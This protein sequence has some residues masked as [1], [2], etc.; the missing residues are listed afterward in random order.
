MFG[1]ITGEVLYPYGGAIAVSPES[2]ITTDLQIQKAFPGI[3][4]LGTEPGAVYEEQREVNGDWWFATNATFESTLNPNVWAQVTSSAASYAVVLRGNGS[5]QR[6]SAPAGA[7]AP[8]AWV[9]LWTVD[10]LGGQFNTPSTFVTNAEFGNNLALTWNAPAAIMTASK[11]NVVDTASAA[12]SL[13][14]DLQVGGTSKWSVRKDGTLTVGIVPSSVLS[15]TISLTTQVSGIL[16]LGNGGTG[17]ATLAAAN[18]AVIN[19]NNNFSAAQTV[20]GTITSSAAA[21]FTA[22][23]TGSNTWASAATG[24]TTGFIFNNTGSAS[25]LL[26]DMQKN[27]T[28]QWKVSSTGATTQLGALAIVGAIT[29]ATTGGFSGAVTASQFNGSGAGLTASTVPN[30]ALAVAYVQS[31]GAGTNL[32]STGGVNPTISI[33]AGPTFAGTVTAGALSTGGAVNAVGNIIAQN[34]I[35]ASTGLSTPVN[36]GAGDGIF[37]RSAS[38]GIIWLG[39]ASDNGDMNYNVNVASSFAFL[40]SNG[41]AFCPISGGAYTNAS[42]R[43]WKTNIEPIQY[44]LAEVLKMKPSV[45]NWKTD[46]RRELGFIAQDVERHMPEL[47]RKDSK[48]FRLLHNDGIIPVLVRA[49]QQQE[50]RIR[51]LE[52]AA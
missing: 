18:I 39:G 40:N 19:A 6:L 44:G 42:D 22:S 29:G 32:G 47:V 7:A 34:F 31:V 30:S 17:A 46:G 51:A 35:V 38:G 49:I 41:G 37:Q 24:A 33:S 28:S 4:M 45:Y 5:M 14:Q 20:A 12:A 2:L 16:P 11:T 50:K 36:A 3:E 13:L 23:G 27:A 52:R 21:A 8:L 9:T 10:A 25:T 48:G 1:W 43:R 15:G 26:F